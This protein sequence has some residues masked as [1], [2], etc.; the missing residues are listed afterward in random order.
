VRVTRR[1]WVWIL[2]AL[3]ALVVVPGLVFGLGVPAHVGVTGGSTT[4]ASSSTPGPSAGTRQPVDTDLKA[5]L[6]APASLPEGESVEVQFTLTN[7]SETGLYVLEW[8]TPLEGIYGDIFHVE[9]D[10]EPVPYNGPLVMRGDP[11]G[12]DYV[13]LDSGES[14]SATV[15]L[16]AVGENGAPAYDFSRPGCYTIAFISPRISHVAKSVTDMARS[17]EDLHPIQIPSEPVRVEI[18]GSSGSADQRT[19]AEGEDQVELVLEIA[20]D[21]PDHVRENLKGD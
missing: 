8:Y 10:G 19:V 16:T 4:P 6:Q 2:L 12:D 3:A 17:V 11:T 20:E 1:S 5:V 14:A 21:L 7:R 18:T 13:H 15:D 9:R